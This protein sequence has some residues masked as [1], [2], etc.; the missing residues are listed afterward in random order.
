MDQ[1]SKT[2]AAF[3]KILGSISSKNRELLKVEIELVRQIVEPQKH[4]VSSFWNDPER[5]AKTREAMRE[6]GQAR[7]VKLIA[8]W[9]TSG[10]EEI[11]DYSEA[12]KLVGR[13]EMTV[14]IAVGKGGG[15]GYFN[16]NDDVI[17]IRR[18]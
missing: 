2:Q 8:T 5:S 11:V 18:L 3:H 16:H 14:R 1:R 13:A 4:P 17:T 10:R 9:R 15:T 6:S 7:R 12:A